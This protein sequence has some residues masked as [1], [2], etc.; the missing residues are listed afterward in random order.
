MDTNSWR[1]FRAL[2]ASY[3]GENYG[4]TNGAA[5]TEERRRKKEKELSV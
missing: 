1:R 4:I 5:A 3:G 2:Q